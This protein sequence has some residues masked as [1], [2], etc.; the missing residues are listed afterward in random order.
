MHRGHRYSQQKKNGFKNPFFGT[1]VSEKKK[2]TKFQLTGLCF[3]T[4]LGGKTLFERCR[5]LRSGARALCAY[6]LF[7]GE[8]NYIRMIVRDAQ[9]DVTDYHERMKWHRSLSG[10]RI[11]IGGERNRTI[12]PGTYNA[13]KNFTRAWILSQWL[14]TISYATEIDRLIEREW[15]GWEAS[16]RIE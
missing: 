2:K 8:I 11:F 4:R 1:F 16:S 14:S 15:G 3:N 9:L 13:D 6:P 7:C 10:V 12:A 5:N